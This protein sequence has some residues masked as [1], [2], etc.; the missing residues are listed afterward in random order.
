[1]SAENVALR[2]PIWMKSPSQVRFDGVSSGSPNGRERRKLADVPT[3]GYVLQNITGD[4][5]L[6]T[7]PPSGCAPLPAV[8]PVVG[9]RTNKQMIWVYAGW[10]VTDVAENQTVRDTAETQ[11]IREAVSANQTVWFCFDVEG[12]VTLRV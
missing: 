4:W 10:G 3:T 7:R 6:D 12:A 2:D 1:M 5:V 11:P 9:I 8:L